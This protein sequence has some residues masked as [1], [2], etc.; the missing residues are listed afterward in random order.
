ME[1]RVTLNGNDETLA[2]KREDS[3]LDVLRRHGYTGAKRGCDSGD[4][5]FCTVIVDGE[6]TRSCVT[7]AK[8]VDGAT[9]ETIE[10]L[11]TRGDLHPLQEAFVE[12]T[13]VQCG[14]CTPGMVMRSVAL[15]REN[16]DPSEGEVRDA[17]DDVL[18]RCT[19]YEKPVQAILDA[20][21]RMGGTDATA[22]DGGE[23]IDD[24][25]GGATGREND[26]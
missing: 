14:F 24:R 11:G 2:A 15:L 13:A 18:C 26:E 16:P 25:D 4:C 8:E 10:G 17:L 5:G 21:D 19:G 20:A 22:V 12:H 3:L 1:I 7:P 6:A 23:P 9:I